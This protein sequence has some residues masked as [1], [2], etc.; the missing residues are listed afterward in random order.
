M[1]KCV[2][3]GGGTFNPIACHLSLAAP[4]FGRTARDMARRFSHLAPDM[5]CVL[6]LT[7]MAD[8]TSDLI[9]NLD[10]A[11]YVSGLLDD[12]LVKIIIMNAAICDFE[13]KNPSTESR[14]S[15]QKDYHV[16]MKGVKGKILSMIKDRRPDIVVC[17]F[18]TTHGATNDQQLKKGVAS[19]NAN[20]INLVIANDVGTYKNVLISDSGRSYMDD[21]GALIDRMI[22]IAVGRVFCAEDYHVVD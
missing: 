14:L 3:I 7:K 19:M 1:N 11:D 9:T 13:I 4:A 8:H 10:V 18:K 2:I 21:R 16:V 15:S 17:G 22:R 12:P 5:E 6:K 20:N